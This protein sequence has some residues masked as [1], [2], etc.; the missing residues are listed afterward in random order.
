LSSVWRLKSLL[1]L[2]LLGA[3]VLFG[4]AG[5]PVQEMSNA[6]QAISAAQRAGANTAAPDLMAQAQKHLKT[7]Q[8]NIGRHEYR[9]ARDEA[10]LA[11]TKA[12]EARRIA[13]TKAAETKA[14]ANLP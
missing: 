13:E 4:C 7:A 12:M 9:V 3:P 10:E 8:S 14:P 1:A 6:R 11:R 2:S 5:A